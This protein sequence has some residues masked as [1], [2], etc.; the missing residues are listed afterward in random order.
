MIEL[1][2]IITVIASFIT[3]AGVIVAAVKKILEK[4]LQP[5]SDRIDKMDKR[6]CRA[7]LINFLGDVEN[8]IE[9]DEVQIKFAYEVYDHYT[10]V[11]H[12]NSYIHDKWER[13]MNAEN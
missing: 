12:C 2:E 3:A 6:Q 11:L 8:G 4:I 10:N 1:K 5:V 13:V 7:F 9:K